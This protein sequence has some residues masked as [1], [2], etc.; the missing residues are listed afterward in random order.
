MYKSAR[1]R[2][3]FHSSSGRLWVVI[4]HT[5]QQLERLVV[6]PIPMI[7]PMIVIS[8]NMTERNGLQGLRW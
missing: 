2:S 1:V 5:V 4:R 8:I 6:T 7:G 3:R